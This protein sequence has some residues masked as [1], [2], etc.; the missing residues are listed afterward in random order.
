MP[1][2]Q[3]FL[4]QNKCTTIA[5]VGVWTTTTAYPLPAW[6]PAIAFMGTTHQMDCVR[7][8]TSGA[9]RGGLGATPALVKVKQASERAY[10]FDAARN[11]K[12]SVWTAVVNYRSVGELKR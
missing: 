11:T 3:I 6:A 8:S 1:Y 9:I 10:L 7:A 2:E 12:K 5:R 4:N